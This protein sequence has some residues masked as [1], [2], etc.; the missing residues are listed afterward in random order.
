MMR[1][2]HPLNALQRAGGIATL[3][4]ALLLFV[5]PQ[6]ANAQRWLQTTQVIAPVQS[7]TPTRALL[8]TLINVIDRSDS[9]AIKRAPD[10]PSR[11]VV[12]Q[13]E[14]ELLNQEG[15]GLSSANY[16]FIDYR[17]EVNRDGF[18]ERIT[19]LFF[20][21][22]P[23]GTGEEDIPIM[24]LSARDSWV[25]DVLRNKGTTL[26]TNEAA[27]KPFGDQIAFAKIVRERDARIVEIGDRTVRDGFEAKKRNLVDKI[28]RLSYSSR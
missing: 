14:D 6:D 11:T 13:L 27:L 3:A 16:V 28:T 8:D 26:V 25:D 1:T 9:L 20:I 2:I 21:Y 4:L 24:Y 18:R 17:F 23:P 10:D 19:D 7:E 5:G 22:R 15:I 12:S